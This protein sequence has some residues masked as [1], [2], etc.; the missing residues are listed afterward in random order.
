MERCSEIMKTTEAVQPSTPSVTFSRVPNRELKAKWKGAPVR[1]GIV[2]NLDLPLASYI[3]NIFG[4]MTCM[5]AEISSRYTLIVGSV[6]V[7]E[8][9]TRILCSVLNMFIVLA[10]DSATREYF[11]DSRMACFAAPMLI[12]TYGRNEMLNQIVARTVGLMYAISQMGIR[13]GH[14]LLSMDLENNLHRIHAQAEGSSSRTQMETARILSMMQK[15]AEYCQM[16]EL[17]GFAPIESLEYLNPGPFLPYPSYPLLQ[18]FQEPANVKSTEVIFHYLHHGP[19]L[20]VPPREGSSPEDLKNLAEPAISSAPLTYA[21]ILAKG[22]TEDPFVSREIDDIIPQSRQTSPPVHFDVYK[23]SPTSVPVIEEMMNPEFTMRQP[24]SIVRESYVEP[25]TGTSTNE[26]LV[27]KNQMENC[28]QQGFAG[29]KLLSYGGSSYQ[30][31]TKIVGGVNQ[32]FVGLQTKGI[33]KP[34]LLP[35][36]R[37]LVQLPGTLPPADL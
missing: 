19:Y 22:L 28:K 10:R 32:I 26:E 1:E 25:T 18:V 2:Q 37:L 5:L 24:A 36:Y 27:P 35:L 14:Y 33:E 17:P 7:T 6:A 34:V 31:S 30:G 23:K 12:L 8:L 20:I 15:A 11:L 4:A 16:G 9:D 13:G 29:E 21:E 3:Q